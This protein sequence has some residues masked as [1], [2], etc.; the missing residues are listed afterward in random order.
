MSQEKATHE[1]MKQHEFNMIFKKYF[2]FD[3]TG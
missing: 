3:A 2:G 1:S